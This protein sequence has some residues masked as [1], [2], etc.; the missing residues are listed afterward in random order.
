MS[1]LIIE[2]CHQLG[3]RWMDS[4][5]T[6]FWWNLSVVT[7]R[8]WL[9][10]KDTWPKKE[11][12]LTW[13][14]QTAW[15]SNSLTHLFFRPLWLLFLGC[16]S[17]IIIIDDRK[18]FRIF[19]A[20]RHFESNRFLSHHRRY[21]SDNSEI[22]TTSMHDNP[23]WDQVS[24][25][26]TNPVP[27]QKKTHKKQGSRVFFI[28]QR[29]HKVFKSFS[30][31]SAFPE[32]E[33]TLAISPGSQLFGLYHGVVLRIYSMYRKTTENKKQQTRDQTKNVA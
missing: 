21:C 10:P 11:K 31:L 24:I 17:L 22:A 26:T 30:N 28:A 23:K 25:G 7:L 19:C 13:H 33:G 18:A 14:I 20:K 5:P 1:T 9:T 27:L 4:W 29:S 3:S 32:I 6:V 16:F 2:I 8:R 12:L 15:N